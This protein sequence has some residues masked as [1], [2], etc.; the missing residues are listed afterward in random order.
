MDERN[1]A[2]PT[3]S[4]EANCKYCTRCGRKLAIDAAYCDG[5]GHALNKKAVPEVSFAVR[6]EYLPEKI[7]DIIGK[8]R[9]YYKQRFAEMKDGGGKVCWNWFACLSWF[10]FAYRKMPIEAAISFVI[11]LLLGS[12]GAASL[13]LRLAFLIVCGAFGNYA[14][15]KHIER[16]IDKIDSLPAAMREN[17]VKEYGG[18]SGI[19]LVIA[20]LV[21]SAVG[22]GLGIIDLVWKPSIRHALRQFFYI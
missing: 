11:Y 10:W 19:L 20:F 18:V 17:A 14:Y 3:P 8:Q 13:A 2:A 6:K 15:L 16:T 12:F 1:T 21:T 4:G 9:E 7:S 22:G 5:C